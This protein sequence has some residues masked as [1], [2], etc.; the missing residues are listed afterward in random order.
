MDLDTLHN[1]FCKYFTVEKGRTYRTVTSYKYN[2]NE[3]LRWLK[4]NDKLLDVSSLEDHKVLRE[5][6][7]YLSQRVAKKTV[8]QRMLSLKTF[9][10]Y[11]RLKMSCSV[12]LLIGSI[13]P[14]K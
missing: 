5:F 7:Y 4:D 2:F 9:C 11:L 1:D 12:I 8:R 14:K 3:F 10:K 6:M 13:F